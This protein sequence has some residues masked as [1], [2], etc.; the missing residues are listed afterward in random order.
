MEAKLLVVR[1]LMEE[2]KEE[3]NRFEEGKVLHP[4]MA[5]TC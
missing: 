4:S 1:C 3:K 2:R 5:R